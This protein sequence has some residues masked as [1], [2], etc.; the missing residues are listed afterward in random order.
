LWTVQRSGE[1]LGEMV[2]IPEAG[3][4]AVVGVPVAGGC[5]RAGINR[6]GFFSQ[7]V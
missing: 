2:I 3:I 7:A 4:I 5:G 6:D 1:P